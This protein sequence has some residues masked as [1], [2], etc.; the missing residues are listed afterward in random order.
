MINIR[1][2]WIKCGFAYRKELACVSKLKKGS[3]RCFESEEM[4]FV[5]RMSDSLNG[6]QGLHNAE[7]ICGVHKGR[8]SAMSSSRQQCF[9][10]WRGWQNSHL[11][12]WTSLIWAVVANCWGEIYVS[13]HNRKA[14]GKQ[15]LW[16]DHC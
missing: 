12:L 4:P 16:T 2:N 14:T 3:A 8:G 1:L 11:P 10:D 6:S 13:E 9:T 5:P 7:H 15:I